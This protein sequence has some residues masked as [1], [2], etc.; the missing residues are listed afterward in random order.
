MLDQLVESR[1]NSN[2]TRRRGG[3]LLTAFTLVFSVLTFALLYSLFSY[4]LAMANERLD[5]SSLVSPVNPPET[6][7]PAQEEIIKPKSQNTEKNVDK[8]PSRVEN[9][10]RIDEPPKTTPD[11]ISTEKTKNLSRPQT[12]FTIDKVDSE[13]TFS[14]N[15]PTGRNV[16]SG[17]G[18]SESKPVKDNSEVVAEPPPPVVKKPETK[19]ALTPTTIRKTELLNG[20]AIN[21]VKP[22]YPQPAKIIRAAG[23]VN[24]QITIDENG[25][26]TSAN[27]IDGHPLLRQVSEQAARASKFTST[28]LNGHKVKVTGV[29]VY[30]FAIQ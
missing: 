1:N 22:I 10:Q 17:N 12:A 15:N 26:V 4:N 29:I 28:V 20:Q 23:A 21:L 16:N 19:S 13:G 14:G 7:P 27:A 24:V 25:N 2:A 8:L 30:N 9:M 6:A 3:F 18:L 5:I 11:G